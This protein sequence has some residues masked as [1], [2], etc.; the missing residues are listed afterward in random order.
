MD[1]AVRCPLQFWKV[2][3]L[4]RQDGTLSSTGFILGQEDIK[5]LPGFEEEVFAV[6][7]AQTTLMELESKTGLS[8][9]DLKNHDHL[10]EGGAPGTLELD[11]ENGAKRILKPIM[12]ETDIVV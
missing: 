4:V 3:V 5:G 12:S 2:C 8:F 1:F 7:L 11:S 6:A 10:A 9:G